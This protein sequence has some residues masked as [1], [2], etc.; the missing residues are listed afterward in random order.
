MF[1][2]IAALPMIF[3]VGAI[4]DVDDMMEDADLLA[5]VE[6][7]DCFSED[8]ESAGLAL[9]QLRASY[10]KKEAEA[11]AKYQYYGAEDLDF[12]AAIQEDSDAGIAFVQTSATMVT[13]RKSSTLVV[14]ADGSVLS[15]TEPSGQTVSSGT[16]FAVSADGR[17]HVE[18]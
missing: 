1:L 10:L 9:A 15:G 8:C 2:K 11:A 6:A 14:S 13:S 7:E 5:A 3:L 12:D 18:M 4:A 16:S 17:M